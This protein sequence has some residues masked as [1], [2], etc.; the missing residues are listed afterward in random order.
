MP[1]VRPLVLAF[2][3]ERVNYTNQ[4]KHEF[5]L[6]NNLLIAPI[7]NGREDPSGASLKDNLYLPDHRTMWI[8]L[9]TG[10][11][12]IGGRIYDKR[13]E[14]RRVGEEWDWEEGTKNAMRKVG[15]TRGAAK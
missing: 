5:M 1:I 12:L 15:T 3:H 14:E 6:G 4:V 7:T 11:K 10:K 2:P 13:S 8:D 9:F